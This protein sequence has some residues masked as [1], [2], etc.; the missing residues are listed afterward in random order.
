MQP[1]NVLLQCNARCRYRCL[2]NSYLRE[3]AKQMGA[4]D[5]MNGQSS[6]TRRIG[7]AQIGLTQQSSPKVKDSSVEFHHL[8]NSRNN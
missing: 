7:G 4:G 3:G 2:E 6:K 5:T 1:G 8:L